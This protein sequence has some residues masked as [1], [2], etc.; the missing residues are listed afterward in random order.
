MTRTSN[1]NRADCTGTGAITPIP[2]NFPFAA[3]TDLIVYQLDTSNRQTP[4]T[5]NVDYTVAGAGTTSG[6]V[7]PVAAIPSGYHWTVLREVDQT[8]ET[9]IRNQGAYY[10]EIIEDALDKLTDITQQLS[11]RMDR[12]VTAA[13]TSTTTL[14][15]P[16]GQVGYALGWPV[17]ADALGAVP[18]NVALALSDFASSSSAA[19]GAGLVGYAYAVAYGANTVGKALK[20]ITDAATTLAGRATALEAT[21]GNASSSGT[22]HGACLL[23][24]SGGSLVLK[25]WRGNGLI[26]NGATCTIPT[27]GISLAA[28]G[29][30]AGTLYYVYAYMN[31]GTMTLEAVTTTHTTGADGVEV[32][33]GATNRTLVGMVRPVAGPAF[34]A[35][36]NCML[37]RSWFNRTITER[38]P[39]SLMASAIS[40]T[41]TSYAEVGTTTRVEWLQWSDEVVS[42]TGYPCVKSESSP[43]HSW[44]KLLLDGADLPIGADAYEEDC[45]YSEAYTYMFFGVN[46]GYAGA[47]LPSVVNLP[48][49]ALVIAEGYHYTSVVLKSSASGIYI[50]MDADNSKAYG[51][52]EIVIEKL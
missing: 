50:Q 12:A 3:A 21:V 22:S 49:L 40:T 20:D 31:S 16:S 41:S 13:P 11:E 36:A 29:L 35:A 9:D 47:S 42:L 39:R 2:I 48:R 15:L 7:T 1:L 52:T 38:R 18:S 4:L 26:I 37:V 17:S 28:T 44:V 8:Q 10:P 43:V 25:P 30:T 27:A 32:K 34:S 46:T 14:Q 23:T 45:A 33:S 51:N 19:K 6:T 24:L 5:L